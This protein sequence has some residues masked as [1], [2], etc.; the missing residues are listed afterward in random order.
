MTE[1]GTH[2]PTPLA[3]LKNSLRSL[4]PLG[5][6]PMVTGCSM[7]QNQQSFMVTHGPVAHHELDVFMVSVYVTIAIFVVV[8]SC[9]L[10]AVFRFEDKGSDS[11]DLPPQVHGNA[12]IEG[13]LG[14]VSALMLVLIA[15]P[16]VKD[17]WYITDVPE[18]EAK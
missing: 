14:V 17:V 2:L 7:L 5:L 9:L 1:P 15:V 3:A 8:T 6:V 18:E 16:T 12:L 4:W 13:T 10:Y 11:G